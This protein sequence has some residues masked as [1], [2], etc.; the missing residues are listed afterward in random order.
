[1]TTATR[2]RHGWQRPLHPLQIV[3]MAVFSFYIF[4]GLLLGSGAAE[5]TV[6]TIFSFVVFSAMFLFICC[7]AI[8]PMDKTSYRKKKRGSEAMVLT[9]FCADSSSLLFQFRCL[10]CLRWYFFFLFFF[11]NDD[12]RKVGADI[13]VE[14]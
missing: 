11:L 14:V 2:R 13:P 8:D 3:G 12:G 7:T 4:L 5:I 9:D 1:M 10:I 6:T